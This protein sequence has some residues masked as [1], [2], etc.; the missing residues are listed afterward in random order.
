MLLSKGT[1]NKYIC[2]KNIAVGTV[3]MSTETSAFFAITRLT[4]KARRRC[5]AKLGITFKCQHVQ[6]TIKRFSLAFQWL[7]LISFWWIESF[8]GTRPQPMRLFGF[9]FK[10]SSNINS[11]LTNHPGWELVPILQ[12]IIIEE[13][14][15]GELSTVLWAKDSLLTEAHRVHLYQ[16]VDIKHSK[17]TIGAW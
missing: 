9:N 2:Q 3:R 6:R 5:Y 13:K 17:Y 1:Y 10:R 15:T 8:Y 16:H 7:Q 11:I 14:T 12:I 4:H